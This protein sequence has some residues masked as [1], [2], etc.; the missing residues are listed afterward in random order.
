M[1]SV[2]LKNYSDRLNSI[3]EIPKPLAFIQESESETSCKENDNTRSIDEK[4]FDIATVR[5]ESTENYESSKSPLDTPSSSRKSHRTEVKINMQNDGNQLNA[6]QIVQTFNVVE[7]LTEI[8]YAQ[9]DAGN[10]NSDTNTI[11][12]MADRLSVLSTASVNSNSL[13]EHPSNGNLDYVTPSQMFTE[14]LISS[15]KSYHIPEISTNR[16]NSDAWSPESGASVSVSSRKA[17]GKVSQSF[18][19]YVTSVVNPSSGVPKSG[20][21][22]HVP[23]TQRPCEVSSTANVV[24]EKSTEVSTVK[25]FVFEVRTDQECIPKM[26]L[27]N[28]HLNADQSEKH[29]TSTDIQGKTPQSTIKCSGYSDID[30]AK[31]DGS[32]SGSTINETGL[33]QASCMHDNTCFTPGIGPQ[34]GAAQ[35]R[36]SHSYSPCANNNGGYVSNIEVEKRVPFRAAGSYIPHCAVQNMSDKMDENDSKESFS[37]YNKFEVNRTFAIPAK[38]YRTNSCNDEQPHKDNS[39]DNLQSINIYSFN[40]Q[41]P[42]QFVFSTPDEYFLPRQDDIQPAVI[43]GS[44]G[45]VDEKSVLNKSVTTEYQNDGYVDHTFM[46]KI[47]GQVKCS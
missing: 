47:N 26:S 20:T 46:K 35:T 36:S 19:G 29:S 13:P 1:L 40:N 7:L 10:Q 25:Q 16:K 6:E 31:A 14:P 17:G 3:I 2:E 22:F 32:H 12:N 23:I 38:D 42:R 11:E 28:T 34:S 41:S 15:Q 24:E 21:N 44:Q 39:E 37:N 5:E 8:P 30:V 9:E 27:C 33:G 43:D 18:D 4:R 45:Y